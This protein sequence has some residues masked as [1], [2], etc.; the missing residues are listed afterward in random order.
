MQALCFFAGFAQL[1]R[2]LLSVSSMNE[3]AALDTSDAAVA[4]GAWIAAGLVFGAQHRRGLTAVPATMRTSIALGVLGSLLVLASAPTDT[5]LAGRLI[6]IGTGAAAA[7]ALAALGLLAF[8]RSQPCEHDMHMDADGGDPEYFVER[9]MTD[10]KLTDVRA[11]A[12]MQASRC[13]CV[14]A[15]DA[16]ALES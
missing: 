8:L 11:S 10:A 3:A 15:R 5:S 7:L 2:L 6:H 13:Q 1:L 12:I 9:L 14:A 4:T 16:Q